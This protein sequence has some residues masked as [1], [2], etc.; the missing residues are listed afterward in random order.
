MRVF[1]D[2]SWFFK[3]HWLA[4]LIGVLVLAVVSFLT[5]VPPRVIGM[6]VDLINTDS[7]TQVTLLRF[8]ALILG[9]GLVLYIL[10]FIWRILIFGASLKLARHIRND[11]YTHYTKMPDSLYHKRTTGNLMAI[12]TNDVRAVQA[13]AGE[14]VLTI[15]DAILLG[16]MV[17]GTMAITISWKL[18]LITLLPLPLMAILTSYYGSLLHKRFGVAQAAFSSLNDTVQENI[19]GIKVMKA[20][21]Q[22]QAENER[23]RKQ[24]A[25]VVDKNMRVA[26]VD[27]LFDPTISGVIGVCYIL[28]ISFGARY[29]LADELTIGQLTTF[30][31]YLGLLIWPM[32]ALG[33]F[34][35]VVERGRASYD[36]IREVLQNQT[37]LNEFPGAI[38]KKIIGDLKVDIN[39]FHYDGNSSAVLT[40]VCFELKAGQ[41][42]GIVGKTGSGKTTLLSLLQRNMDVSKGA[43]YLDSINLKQYKLRRV[44]EVF[45]I[46]PQEHFLF[47]ATISE[48]VAFAKPQATIAE[49]ISACQLACVHED[50]LRF[51]DGY[52]TLVGERGVTLSG[53]Q[54]QR[55][56]I[57]RAILSSPAILML[58]DSLSA[59]DAKTEERILNALRKH[60]KEQTLIMTAH[61]LSAISHA[62]LILVM[63]NGGIAQAGTHHE[64][65][66]QGGWY[67]EMY[68][69]QKLETIV[70][71]GG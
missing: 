30:V 20:F 66:R 44:K 35:N 60:H 70:E 71:Q 59:V 56:S 17:I 51:P 55:I 52:E 49:I 27:A 10:R 38:D 9:I 15:V 47:S 42:L 41:T 22:E 26:K 63:E 4:Y 29:V 34:F 40:D 1:L 61:R 50:I 2:L 8:V 62:N 23:F 5:L 37:D 7:L 36:R 46:V 69:R 67:K 6:V 65:M 12:S 45:G 54:K 57:A 11:L 21:G 39:S 68:E 31:V 32:L 16:G 24:S 28:A 53:G 14:G 18:T 33:M 43:I 64:L 3:R 13:T 19:N 58:D 25:I 48:N